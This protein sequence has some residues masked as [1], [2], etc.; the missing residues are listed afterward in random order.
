MRPRARSKDDEASALRRILRV[1]SRCALDVPK[2]LQSS[3]SF[4]LR[5]RGPAFGVRAFRS[6]ATQWPS[7]GP[8]L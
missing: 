7:A 5:A 8:F 6:A 1:F 2:R 4:S 3:C